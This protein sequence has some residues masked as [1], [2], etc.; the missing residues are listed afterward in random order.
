MTQT[1]RGVAA[2]PGLGIGIVAIYRTGH[3]TLENIDPPDHLNGD[4]EWRRFQMA[5]RLVD[6]EMDRL[7]R[8]SSGLVMEIFATHRVILQDETLVGGVRRA[9]FENNQSAAIATF[10]VISDLA[11]MFR[12]LEDDYFALRTADILD[13][14]Q[15]LLVQLGAAPRRARLDTLPP[16]TILIAD[17]LTPTD[18]AQLEPA[19]VVG[20]ALAGGA[21]NSHSAILARSLGIPLVCGLGDGVLRV[22]PHQPA[23]VDGSRGALILHPDGAALRRYHAA[24]QS[25]IEERALAARHSHELATTRDHVQI[26]V[27]ANANSPE[28]VLHAQDAGADG[29]GLLRTEYL[30]QGR[31]QPPSLEEQVDTYSCFM[32]QVGGSQ[33]TVRALD[34]GGDKPVDYFMHPREG[35]PFLGLRG[36]RLLISQPDILRT[37][38]RALQITAQSAP[39]GLEVRFMLPMISTVEEVRVVH[40][41]LE[42]MHRDLPRLKTGVMI[43]VPSA[44]LIANRLAPRVDF[45]SIGTND[46]A[47]YT[48]AS[49]RTHYTVG[50]LADPLHPSVLKLIEMTCVAGQAAGIPVSL[51]GELAGDVTATPLLL[52]LGLHEFSA[53]LPAVSLVKAAV[54]RCMLNE[55]RG[56]AQQA[57]A[58]DDADAVRAILARH[59][60]STH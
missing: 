6:E 42:E 53:P 46:L 50:A 24:R 35:N 60:P 54:R 29:I 8:S 36:V 23:V 49:D 14:G 59:T 5:Q 18:V 26:S 25:Q 56:L 12:S 47:Q 48:L 22:T 17:D 32:R 31:S 39:A 55:C 1:F 11:E 43:E 15:R 27:L 4:Q 2:A 38:Y 21:P 33:L 57:L 45:F 19:Q 28:D 58:S 30:F 52:G 34:A 51:C 9:I 16:N 40:A 3:F 7:S 44:A 41:L 20:V 13:I 37:Q 10:Q